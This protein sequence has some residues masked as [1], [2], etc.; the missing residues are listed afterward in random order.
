MANR[1]PLTTYGQ[2]VSESLSSGSYAPDSD[3]NRKGR[4]AGAPPR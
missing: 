1:I 3:R 4:Q 2:V